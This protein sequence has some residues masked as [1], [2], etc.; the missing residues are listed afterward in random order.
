MSSGALQI[1]CKPTTNG[2]ASKRDRPRLLS[3]RFK[4]LD[5]RAYGS[6]LQV[7]QEE[8]FSLH[9]LEKI[10]YIIII[11]AIYRPFPTHGG[12]S[13]ICMSS[14]FIMLAT[15]L[16]F[17][18]RPVVCFSTFSTGQVQYSSGNVV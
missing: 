2:I 16:Y 1:N 11:S 18:F 15:L 9:R 10:E 8:A 4:A 14:A 6:R 5:A 7:E 17:N 3:R 13:V 12:T